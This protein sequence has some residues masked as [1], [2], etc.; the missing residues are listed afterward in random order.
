MEATAFVANTICVA[1]DNKLQREREEGRAIRANVYDFGGS[2]LI[3]DLLK[4]FSELHDSESAEKA[5]DD[6]KLL[7]SL[8]EHERQYKQYATQYLVLE[9]QMWIR[10]ADVYNSSDRQER[11]KFDSI[12]KGTEKALLFWFIDKSDDEIDVILSRCAH[13]AS[14]NK[15]RRDELSIKRQLLKENDYKRTAEIIIKRAEDTGR[16][17][18]SVAEF[19]DLWV[20]R[21]RRVDVATATAY[22]KTTRDK[23][24]S[25]GAVGLKDNQ[26]T[27]II[28]AE[29]NKDEV[30]QAVVN[31]INGIIAD[32]Y[33]LK[34]LCET[35]NLS[36]P[37]EKVTEL[38]NTLSKTIKEM[39]VTP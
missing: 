21:N 24:L 27:Y 29:N 31:R 13:G 38:S 9:C 36:L 17:K 33:S 37:T 25:M 28:P 34:D 10:I 20:G 19:C 22:V 15:Q 18:C 26:G 5:V 35:W 6:L 23:L 3:P 14:V 2:R 30:L 11:E 4:Q 7:K 39:G 8:L 16:T 12:F 32:I 1:L